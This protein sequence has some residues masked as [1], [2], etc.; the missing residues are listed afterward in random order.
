LADWF[1]E[2]RAQGEL[3][4]G[5]LW[6]PEVQDAFLE[7]LRTGAL[8]SVC[9]SRDGGA[10]GVTVTS[11]GRWRREWFR[12]STELSD[13]LAEGAVFLAAHPPA[14]ADR[15]PGARWSRNGAGSPR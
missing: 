14:S 2:G 10:L 9:V 4:L 8:V 12:S 7:C 5:P 3:E 15:K 13:W 1:D 11:D 6:T